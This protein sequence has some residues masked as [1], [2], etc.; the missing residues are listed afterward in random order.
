MDTEGIH[1]CHYDERAQKSERTG[2][3]AS[4]LNEEQTLTSAVVPSVGYDVQDALSL[5]CQCDSIPAE[6]WK[7]YV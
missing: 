5:C 1:E 3:R 7:F 2:T 4:M 6:A